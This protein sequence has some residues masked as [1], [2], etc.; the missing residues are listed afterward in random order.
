MQDSCL[1]VQKYCNKERDGRG[2][3]KVCVRGQIKTDQKKRN[4]VKVDTMKE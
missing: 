2:K 1:S 4:E 3:K